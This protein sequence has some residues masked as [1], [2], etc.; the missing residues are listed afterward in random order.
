[1]F[2]KNFSEENCAAFVGFPKCLVKPLQQ[3]YNWRRMKLPPH[4]RNKVRNKIPTGKFTL[5]GKRLIAR[6]MFHKGMQFVAASILLRQNNGFHD[7]VLHLLAQG[8]EIMQKGLLLANN[9]DVF[10]AQLRDFG[11]DLIKGA[12]A[13]HT[14]FNLKPLKPEM[15]S[16]LKELNKYY[17]QHLLRY[18]GPHDFLSPPTKIKV[19]PFQK[20]ALAL[21]RFGERI[22]K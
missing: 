19:E 13:L 20:R 15:R 10:H 4:V 6:A 18:G 22:L 9:Y 11:H 14:A 16:H 8:I 21:L 2:N 17:G 7:V 5:A 3:A 12:D 1:M